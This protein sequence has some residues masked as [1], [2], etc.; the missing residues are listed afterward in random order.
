MNSPEQSTLGR[1]VEYAGHYDA[2]RLFPIPRS[3]T[4]A[5]LAFEGPLPF[6][7][8]DVWNAYELSWLD[9]RG[10]PQVALAELRVPARS[11]NLIE[12]KSLKLYLNGFMQTPMADARQVGER[13]AADL[14]AAAGA[15]VTVALR[16]P[17]QL[18]GQPLGVLDGICIDDA[19]VEIDRYRDPD[20]SLLASGPEQVDETLLSHVLKSNCP[21]TGQPDWASVQIRYAGP[22]LE[23][24]ALLRYLVAFRE[25]ADFHEACVERIWTDL[26]RHL[27][28]SRLAVYARYTRRGGLDINPYRSSE[29]AEQPDNPRLPRQ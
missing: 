1:A 24:A 5:G 29:P 27:R 15:P 3:G 8:V 2:G 14:S 10:R 18:A 23:R 9:P 11:P 13:I 25:H 21:V 26:W 16:T 20:P 6:D 22:R 7:G 17:A 19:E 28:P 4:R 12:S